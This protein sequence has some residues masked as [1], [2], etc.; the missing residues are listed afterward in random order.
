MLGVSLDRVGRPVDA[1]AIWE[2]GLGHCPGDPELH[3]QIAKLSSERGDL[4]RSREHYL[5]TLNADIAGVYTSVDRGI[6]GYKTMHNLAVVE[7]QRGNYEGALKWFTK[8]METAPEFR[9]SAFA[10]FDL[11]KEQGDL[12]TAVLAFIERHEGK[13]PSWNMMRESLLADKL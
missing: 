7:A 6:L 13:S 4:E 5:A 2:T 3:F 8:S 11:A 9:P 10:L 12:H 1:L